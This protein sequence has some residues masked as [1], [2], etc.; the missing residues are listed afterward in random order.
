MLSLREILNDPNYINANEATK[1]AIFERYAP[2]DENFV[3]AN[4]ATQ[5]AIRQRFG[6][7]APP[8]QE[9]TEPTV[10]PVAK[11]KPAPVIPQLPVAPVAS[12]VSEDEGFLAR[13]YRYAKDALISGYESFRANTK[14]E[15]FAISRGAMLKDEEEYGG[16]EVPLAPPEVRERY[17]RNKREAGQYAQDIAEFQ[18]QAQERQLASPLRPETARLKAAMGD[19]LTF[20]ESAKEAGAALFS[21]PVGVIADLGAESLPAMAYMVSTALIGRLAAQNPTAAAQAGG[22]GS[23]ATQF[24]NEYVDRLQ[25]GESHDEAWK[26]A[27][28]RSG[29]IGVFDAV[30]LKT[31]GS[32]ANKIIEA[33]KTGKPAFVAAKEFVKEV[34]TQAG[35]GGA[36]EAAGSLA[37]GEVPNPAAV[38]AEMAG[39]TVTGP[40]EAIGTYQ[41]VK[42]IK[43]LSE[44]DKAIADLDKLN[45]EE[46]E[47]EESILARANEIIGEFSDDGQT[48]SMDDAYARA[49]FELVE[50]KPEAGGVDLGLA[51]EKDLFAEE[52]AKK[53]QLQ[54]AIAEFPEEAQATPLE[55]KKLIDIKLKK[56]LGRPP[57]DI[58]TLEALYEFTQEKTRR[59]R[60]ESGGRKPPVS[61]PSGEEAA[62]GVTG[63]PARTEPTGLGEGVGAAASVGAREE[64]TTGALKPKDQI[65]TAK[66]MMA[67]ISK[68]P[69]N[70]EGVSGNIVG[71]VKSYKGFKF[72]KVQEGS[73][74]FWKAQ[75]PENQALNR[76]GRGDTS[77]DSLGLAKDAINENLDNKFDAEM[78][79]RRLL[80]RLTKEK[81][82]APTEAKTAETAPAAT[83][84]PEGTTEEPTQTYEE[85]L[86]EDYK[87]KGLDNPNEASKKIQESRNVSKKVADDYVQALRKREA[88]RIKFFYGLGS[89]QAFREALGEVEKIEN[90][91]RGVEKRREGKQSLLTEKGGATVLDATQKIEAKEVRERGTRLSNDVE[92]EEVFIDGDS[93]VFFVVDNDVF[94]PTTKEEFDSLAE[95]LFEKAEFYSIPKQKRGI[96]PARD[97]DISL[98][99]I[100]TG[101]VPTVTQEQIDDGIKDSKNQI[102][103]ELASLGQ[104]KASLVESIRNYGS[105]I[106]KQRLLN[107]LNRLIKNLKAALRAYSDKVVSA[108][109]F[110]NH[111]RN[112]M[113]GTGVFREPA[114]SSQ[115]FEVIQK[116]YSRFPKVLEGLRLSVVSPGIGQDNIAGMYIPVERLVRL[117]IGTKGAFNPSTIRHELMHSL[118]QMMTKEAKEA[119]INA[120]HRAFQKA[121]QKHTDLK[122]QAFFHKVMN[123]LDNPSPESLAVAVKAMPSYEFYQYVNPSEFWAVNAEKLFAAK[124]GSGWERFK[125]AVRKLFEALKDTFGFD[126]NYAVHKTLDDL[127]KGEAPRDGVDLV[128]YLLS[129]K[130]VDFLANVDDTIADLDQK[131]ALLEFKVGD[132]HPTMV[133]AIS[134]N[135]LN[136]ALRIASQKLTG[137]SADLAKALLDLKLPTNISFNNG[138]D[139]V[140]RSIDSVSAQQQ[141]RLFRYVEMH[142]PQVYDKY[143]K[144]YDRS[145]SLEAVSKGLAEL[146]KP[147]YNLGP[148][149]AE[150]QTVFEAYDKSIEG[151]TAPGAYSPQFDEI[152]L[153]TNTRTGKSYRVFLHEVVHAATEYVLNTYGTN[154]QELTPGQREAVEELTKM[155]NYA[156]EKLGKEPYGMTNIYE[157]ISE[158]FTNKKFQ[159]LLKGLK[160]EPKKTPFL[161][162]LVKAI[163]RAFGLDNLAGN[164]MAEA[165]KIFSAVRTGAPFAAQPRFAGGKR[166]KRV[167]G[168]TSTPQ[169]SRTQEQT[170]QS[171]IGTANL[172]L[173]GR[174]TWSKAIKIMGSSFWDARNTQLRQVVLGFMNLSHLAEITK[175]KFPQIIGTIRLIEKMIEYRLSILN[176][177]AD[178]SRRWTVAQFKNP[179]QSQIMARI[180]L[181][182]TM[183]S[184][185]P[186]NPKGQP[187][188]AALLQAWAILKPE[189]KQIYRDVRDFYKKSVERMIKEL[190]DRVNNSSLSQQE[191]EKSLAE[192][193]AQF[194]PDKLVSPYFPLRRF[195]EFFFQVGSG[196]F[197]E[198]YEYESADARN[199]AMNNR[200]NEL[201]EGNAQQR[202]L[203]G[204]VYPGNGVSEIFSKNRDAPGV[205]KEVQ[206]LVDSIG[207]ITTP[208]TKAQY[209]AAEKVLQKELN[210]T[211]TKEEVE[212]RF[213]RDE[214]KK[215]LKDNINQLLYVLLPQQSMRKMFINRKNI[216]GASED[217]LRVFSTSAIHSAYQQSRFK[218]SDKLHNNITNALDD[219]RNNPLLSRS[220]KEVYRDFVIELEKRMPVI[221][222]AEDTSFAAKVAGRLSETTFFFMLSA[223]FSAMLN[224]IGMA[225][226]AL[227]YIGGTY[228]YDRTAKLMTKN[229]LRYTSTVPTR[230]IKPLAK[231]DFLE[232][233]FPS[234]AEGYSFKNEPVLHRAAFELAQEGQYEISLVNDFMMLA[235]APSALYTGYMATVKK[236][237]SSLFH[238]T[239]RLN[240]EVVSITVFEM[241]YEK[242]TTEPKKDTRGVVERDAQGNP[243]MNTPE[244]AFQLAMAEAKDMVRASLGDFSRQMKPRYFVG[245]VGSII[246][247]FKQYPVLV[248][249]ILLRNLKL[250]FSLY[251]P[252]ERKKLLAKYEEQL[253]N[254]KVSPAVIKQRVGEYEAHHKAIG[255][256][257][258]RR[259]A[260]ILAVTYLLGGNEASP[261]YSI[262]LG[263]LVNMFA[264]D[265]DDEFFDWENWVKNYVQVELGGAAGDLFAEMGMNPEVSGSLGDFI[266]DSIQKGVVST[267]TGG[268]FADRVS[269]DPV[270]MFYREGRY[271]PDVRESLTE[272]MIANAG[273][274][275]GLAFNWVEAYRLMQEG[276]YQRAFEKSAPALFAKPVTAARLAEEG[277]K[278]TKGDVLVNEFSAWEIAMQSIGL[279]PVR[280]NTA[281][282]RS[283]EVVQREQKLENR[284]KALMNRLWMERNNFDT[285]N[286]VLEEA[287]EFSAKYPL[288][289]IDAKAIQESFDQRAE[290]QAQANNI[291]AR[292]SKK[293]I[294]EAL[295]MMRYGRE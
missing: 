50:D 119:I 172:A 11:G 63:A 242:F 91:I 147:N 152:T 139:L 284:R 250:G 45:A 294:P 136:G 73:E 93:D 222:S 121:I 57:T 248:T 70:V 229:I 51:G 107:E 127:L 62:A 49:R 65:N 179:K 220:E 247:K 154:K 286:D 189:F 177:A 72:Y 87:R 95:E 193:A 109:N 162:R 16:P 275:V 134:N 232:V 111:G 225:Q 207:N 184:L 254:D 288:F 219:I 14:G 48:I 157:F 161:S 213:E 223:P 33:L 198:F 205:L 195:G 80:P 13:N 47:L 145:E 151:L 208:P 256:E 200:V 28:I 274:T 115:V 170:T 12:T 285:F 215:E 122:S 265:E 244:E 113:D 83:T 1:R 8:P 52:T 84:A 224:T 131:V 44:E 5:E 197:K 37:I 144:N 7:A 282:K 100:D 168:P 190:E 203:V 75:S 18:K 86:A 169:T 22:L 238:Q 158:V 89:E 261:F 191:K 77:H 34:G 30:S 137:F 46:I 85:A 209:D 112:A 236:I 96:R 41:R 251:R 187:V 175:D 212:K 120:Y 259:L 160:Y 40:F 216:Q 218:F 67:D 206:D 178:I 227:P 249:Y 92:A 239:E 108:E 201:S 55:A 255:K 130:A 126:N 233:K 174:M 272:A 31:A 155:Y 183:R 150:F 26:N 253:I 280:L 9:E 290:D 54:K 123:F 204:S 56:K 118:E 264:D 132:I 156:V 35:L 21:N 194:G 10:S 61:V 90:R 171:Y 68:Q 81:E 110:L 182:A 273:P 240:R 64:P 226:I 277:G 116:V 71:D 276:Q 166:G 268:N 266:G 79:A 135:D 42:E 74:T 234:L 176:E 58:E 271:S 20:M 142:Y 140:R 287:N 4:P 269:L 59:L 143:F 278:T 23:A 133:S 262:G 94:Q 117:Y 263:V 188:N 99:D 241:A 231:G 2:Q 228:G 6:V 291:G 32:A 243:V 141:K 281:Q 43:K 3:T 214:I 245:P 138:R 237:M 125:S 267:I 102:I 221:L 199:L 149:A 129:A 17:E 186:D 260:G 15:A 181:E 29:V 230:T 36:G 270:T 27:S 293:F 163:L 82:A 165:T 252:F 24:G 39:E 98:Q 258:R 104:K 128:N 153:N 78:F 114:I 279:Q 25:K 60:A 105:S 235:E 173:T 124:L 76:I 202:A 192:I 97:E 292:V 185:D 19:D 295:Q 289:A 283:I 88:E 148:V 164:A 246:F 101:E 53:E 69:L 146:Q 211:P 196:N 210:R 180:M 159:E 103:E 38:I 217:M 257:A 106:E 167:Q 66:Q